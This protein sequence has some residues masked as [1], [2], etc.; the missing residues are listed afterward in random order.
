MMGRG[1]EQ[2]LEAVKQQEKPVVQRLVQR[3]RGKLLGSAKKI[4]INYQ[5][6]SAV[7]FSTVCLQCTSASWLC[8]GFWNGGR[9]PGP[10]NCCSNSTVNCR[11]CAFQCNVEG[12]ALITALT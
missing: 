6:R 1:E 2:L 7:R 10:S 9:F 12:W 11:G 8:A 4:N 3:G 5:V